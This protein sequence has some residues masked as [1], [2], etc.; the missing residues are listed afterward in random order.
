MID[1]SIITGFEWDAGNRSKNEKH[2][3]HYTE[4]E[5]AMVNMPIIVGEDIKHSGREQRYSALSATFSG[6]P[7]FI[8]FTVRN[9]RIRIVSARDMNKK[10]RKDY[11][12]SIKRNT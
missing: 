2:G 5:E 3:V 8:I 10:E 1:F 4:C 6:R 11:N 9:N 7:L 12:E